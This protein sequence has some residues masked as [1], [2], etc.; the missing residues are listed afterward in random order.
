MLRRPK[1]RIGPRAGSWSDMPGRGWR[2]STGTAAPSR[3][4]TPW[5][6]GRLGWSWGGLR[7]CKC[8]AVRVA[9]R[10]RF[11]AQLSLSRLCGW[12]QR[13]A[14]DADR[15]VACWAIAA[16]PGERAP[17]LVPSAGGRRGGVGCASSCVLAWQPQA[18]DE[19]WDGWAVE[20]LGL[21]YHPVVRSLYLPGWRPAVSRGEPACPRRALGVGGGAGAGLR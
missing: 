16:R 7:G 5:T 11:S 18:G 15:R 10:G 4:P 3:E 2:S 12:G 6:D 8:A 9:P 14:A 17:D 19:G 20:G 13:T 1:R 21:A